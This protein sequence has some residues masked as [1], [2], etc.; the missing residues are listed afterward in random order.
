MDISR[1]Q[2]FKY[3][4]VSPMCT[5]PSTYCYKLEKP[6]RPEEN[7]STGYWTW[8][9]VRSNSVGAHFRQSGLTNQC[10]E[11][12]RSPSNIVVMC[13]NMSKWRWKYQEGMKMWI[14]GNHLPLNL[15]IFKLNQTFTF[16]YITPSMIWDT[17]IE[18]TE[19]L[20]CNLRRRLWVLRCYCLNCSQLKSFS[21]N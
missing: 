10:L 14:L 4:L 3:I 19:L 18:G 12:I 6:Y 20:L 5:M 2:F 15:I 13:T 21:E 7:L 11:D 17:N 16:M 9:S 1:W 8:N